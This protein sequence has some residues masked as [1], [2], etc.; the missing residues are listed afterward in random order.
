MKKRS[1]EALD[2]YYAEADSWSRDRRIEAQRSRKLAWVV[3]SV[4]GVIAIAEAAAIVVL[5]PLK[6]VEPYTLMVDRQTGFVQALKP[7]DSQTVSADSA[8]TQSFIVQYVIA[9]EGYD[10]NALQSD[11]RKVGLW[12]S[13][14][15]RRSYI[16]R[17]QATNPESPLSQYPRSSIVDVT[18]KSVTTLSKNTAMVRYDTQRHDNGGGISPPR[19]WMSIVRYGYSGAPMSVADRLINPLG[20]QVFGYRRSVEIAPATSPSTQPALAPAIGTNPFPNLSPSPSQRMP[21]GQATTTI[22]GR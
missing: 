10:I 7:L 18:I 21:T 1:R 5:T 17:M 16:A 22:H 4:F 8:L 11:Y 3:A 12:S 20:F 19:A 14:E 2:A 15:A 13:G 9:R 6:T